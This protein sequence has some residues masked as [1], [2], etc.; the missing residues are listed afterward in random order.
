MTE[1][2]HADFLRDRFGGKNWVLSRRTP[3]IVRRY[4]EDVVCISKQRYAAVEQ[5]WRRLYG[6]PYDAV[7]RDLYMALKVVVEKHARPCFMGNPY[8]YEPEW[9]RAIAALEAE[10]NVR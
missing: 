9:S 5:E 3:N 2:T 8:T 10:A 6:D 4:G 1:I 7:R